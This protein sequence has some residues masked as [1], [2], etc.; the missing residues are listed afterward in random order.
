MLTASEVDIMPQP[1][2][3]AFKPS[4]FPRITGGLHVSGG[5]G[6][7][8]FKVT[9]GKTEFAGSHRFSLMSS[10]S[11]RPW[12]SDKLAF[13]RCLCA[14]WPRRI[15]GPGGRKQIYRSASGGSKGTTV[16]RRSL[17]WS[18]IHSAIRLVSTLIFS[19]RGFRRFVVS[20]LA[21]HSASRSS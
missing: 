1:E 11:F 20:P 17:Q 12:V 9:G 16:Y 18:K 10:S 15:S 21:T 5:W 3:Q 7:F 8:L 14:L 19:W 6:N 13:H 4:H 2:R